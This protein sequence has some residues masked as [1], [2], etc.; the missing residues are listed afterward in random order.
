MPLLY[1]CW[2]FTSVSGQISNL[3][4]KT[5]NNGKV[6]FVHLLGS[7]NEQELNQA[8]PYFLLEK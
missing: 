5:S 6:F 8:F 4:E 7:D 2:R 1:F 3:S